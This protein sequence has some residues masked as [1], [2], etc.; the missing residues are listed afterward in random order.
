MKAR[1]KGQTAYR[2]TYAL[3]DSGSDKTF[4]SESLIEKLGVKG[5]PASLSL[6]T[7][8]SSESADVE[9]VALEVVAVKSGAGRPSVIQ[10]PKVYALLNLPILENC[11]ASDSDFRKWSHLKDL[12]LP[13]VDESGVTILNLNLNLESEPSV[14]EPAFS[15]Y[16]LTDERLNA[17]VEQFWNLERGEALANSLPQF[18]VDDKKAVYMWEQSIELVN[19]HYQMDIPFKSKNPNLPDNRVTAEKRLRS[20]TRRFLRDPELHVK[21]KGGIQELLDKGYAERVSEQELAATPGQTWYLPRHN[22]VNK[23][24][25]EK[26]RIVFDFAATF[27]GTSLNKEVLQGPDFT[28]NQS[29]TWV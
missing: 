25:P 22:V 9:L 3:L 26:L 8:N 5:K 27:D 17:Q 15:N 4:C 16:V 29:L 24:K 28:N 21:Y 2:Y 1:A 14:E 10:L 6:T 23:N 12:R 13:Q 20:V 7:V 19:G 11:I 18:S